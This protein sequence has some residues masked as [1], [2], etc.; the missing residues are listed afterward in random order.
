[1]ILLFTK[2]G[3]CCIP[4]PS[5][6]YTHSKDSRN[7]PILPAVAANS[8]NSTGYD[9]YNVPISA[10][11]DATLF[12][13][14]SVLG[15]LAYAANCGGNSF[16]LLLSA[17]TSLEPELMAPRKKTLPVRPMLEIFSFFSSSPWIFRNQ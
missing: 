11:G 13:V 16:E 14:H 15:S 17:R 5:A 9:N 12:G 2:S 6:G 4:G 10:A 1:L 3:N 7:I 8:D